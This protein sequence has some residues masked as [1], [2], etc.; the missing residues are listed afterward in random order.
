MNDFFLT[1]RWK[2]QKMH[3]VMIVVIVFLSFL[4]GF[5]FFELSS[6]LYFTVVNGD[7]GLERRAA[8]RQRSVTL[9]NLPLI[10]AC[11]D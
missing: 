5:L 9:R 2:P 7:L 6:I 11:S 1:I 4:G 3:N 10:L 8:G